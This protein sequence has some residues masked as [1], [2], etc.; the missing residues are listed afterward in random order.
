MEQNDGIHPL[1]HGERRPVSLL[2]ELSRK[3]K[4]QPAAHAGKKQE[5]L[6]EKGSSL[7]TWKHSHRPN[8]L[9][10]VQKHQPM[11]SFVR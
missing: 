1:H 10:T 11:T 6:I 8:T 4:L 2:D 3:G 9:R 7:S 5:I